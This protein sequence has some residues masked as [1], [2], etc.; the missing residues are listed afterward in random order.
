MP[1]QNEDEF[2]SEILQYVYSKRLKET[3]FPTLKLVRDYAISVYLC[4]SLVNGSRSMNSMN[5]DIDLEVLVNASSTRDKLLSNI[6][7]ANNQIQG[8]LL[9]DFNVH[10]PQNF[11]RSLD[12]KDHFKI[13]SRIHNGKLLLG[14]PIDVR[15]NHKL[16]VQTLWSAYENLEEASLLVSSHNAYNAASFYLH[17]GISTFY[18]ADTLLLG[19]KEFKTRHKA[20]QSL[21]GSSLTSVQSAYYDLTRRANVRTGESIKILSVP[22]KSKASPDDYDILETRMDSILS[23]SKSILNQVQHLDDSSWPS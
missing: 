8:R 16:A 10:T 4:G 18:F 22:L 5:F 13:W 2:V 12:S 15:L 1:D 23:Y 14:E 21:L 20:L 7:K 11:Q 9:F 19:S 6:T 3:I 17:E